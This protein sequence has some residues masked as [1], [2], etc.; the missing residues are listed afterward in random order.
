[1]RS[2]IETIGDIDIIAGGTDAV[3]ERFEAIESDLKQLQDSG[4]DV[5][6]DEIS[7]L[8]SAVSDLGSALGG[9]SGGVSVEDAQ[10]LATSVTAVV[11]AAGDVIERL[12]TTCS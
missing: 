6:S 8:D 2:N 4:S 7:A 1:M 10:Q 5:A 9:L 3:S 12:S 11:N